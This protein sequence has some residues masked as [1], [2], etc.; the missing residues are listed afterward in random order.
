MMN[1]KNTNKKNAKDDALLLF[2]KAITARHKASIKAIWKLDI[3]KASDI[4][5]IV[6]VDDLN[7][8]NVER[9]SIE[10]EAAKE[11]K[12]LEERHKLK[13]H[14][15]FYRLS[16][17]FG[18]VMKGSINIFSEIKSSEAIY[19]PT[20]FFRPLQS[21]VAEGKILGTREALLRFIYSIKKRLKSADEMKIEALENIYTSVVNAGQAPLIAA[22]YGIPVQRDIPLFLKKH[23]SQNGL[24]SAEHIRH[25][26]EIIG[27]FKDLE[28]GKLKEIEG[29]NI[30]ALLKK[31]K[32]FVERMESLSSEIS[33]KQGS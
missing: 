21:L 1:A 14:T 28:H 23:F 33:V 24:L 32:H 9:K 4:S 27:T 30:D 10:L 8:D 11:E 2:V 12:K 5:L 18:E 15:G 6:L 13:V 29:R 7:F 17:Y 26:E 22:N 19:D 3:E 20:G 25:C 16:D 31:A